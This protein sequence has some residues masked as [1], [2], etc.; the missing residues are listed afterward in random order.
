[1]KDLELLRQ[2]LTAVLGPGRPPS[3]A[4]DVRQAM[5]AQLDAIRATF[6]HRSAEPLDAGA[7]ARTLAAFRASGR[8]ES[9]RELNHV[10]LAAG[11]VGADGYCLLGDP[12]LRTRLLEMA[13]VAPKRHNRFRLFRSLLR[14]YWTFPLHA[15]ATPA[16]ARDGWQV[17]RAWLAARYESFARRDGRRPTWF[18]LLGVHQNLLGAEPCAPYAQS[19]L[20]GNG[21][22]L[23]V[24]LEALHIPE[25]A[26]VKAEA[27]LAQ[28]RAAAARPDNALR[29]LLPRL[30]EVANGAVGI[31]TDRALQRK[32]IALLLR[33][34]AACQDYTP[35]P[36]LFLPALDLLGTP[37]GARA[38]WDTEVVDD[39]GKP[40]GV[41]RE[42]VAAWLKDSL[43]EGFFRG[44]GMPG[45]A[46]IAVAVWKKYAPLMDE[47]WIAPGLANPHTSLPPAA[48]AV[49]MLPTM[50]KA[51]VRSSQDIFSA[52]ARLCPVVPDIPGGALL[53]RLSGRLVLVHGRRGQVES[54]RWVDLPM[55]WAVRLRAEGRL[56]L[57]ALGRLLAR[58]P[59]YLQLDPT[60]ATTAEELDGKLRGLLFGPQ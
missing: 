21:T 52:C 9:L 30:V 11:E 6:G 36:E 31:E 34:W 38:T 56:D 37:W 10:C 60:S 8:V 47:L 12:P 17:L 13:E 24:A 54:A 4:W 58:S 43:I 42:M 48:S 25:T 29:I 1:M 44:Q 2:R 22:D 18:T 28:L 49:P 57:H 35:A 55:D 20:R 27:V 15:A 39:A 14:A 33:R 50:P 3:G 45:D 7:L 23:Q 46:E 26:W 19:L 16:A 59:H 51:S 41:T 40:C 5:T 53:M 32:G